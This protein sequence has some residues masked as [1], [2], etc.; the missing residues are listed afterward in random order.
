[1]LVEGLSGMAHRNGKWSDVWLTPPELLKPLGV[2]D[3]DPCAAPDPRPWPTA[4]LHYTVPDNGLLK[5][6]PG[7]VWLNPPYGNETARWLGRL[8]SHGN[9]IALIFARTDT[10]MFQ[11]LV[12]READAILF[13]AGRIKFCHPDGTPAGSSGAPCCLVAYGRKN[14]DVLAGCGIE[15]H[16]VELKA[17]PLI[18]Q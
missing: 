16:L 5:D 12:F 2:F 3:L 15:G 7:R 8:V 1:M 13:I 10:A 9:G 14:F 17:H 11:R 6:W 18:V 4:K